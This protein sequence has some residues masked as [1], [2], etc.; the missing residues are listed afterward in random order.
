MSVARTGA[1]ASA[2]VAK[3]I[4]RATLPSR[5]P[6]R[7]NMP[8]GYA[9]FNA[10]PAVRPTSSG[11]HLGTLAQPASAIRDPCVARLTLLSCEA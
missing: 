9:T 2:V 8:R 6:G 10:A 4:A 1:F 5:R 3:T 7:L 11:V